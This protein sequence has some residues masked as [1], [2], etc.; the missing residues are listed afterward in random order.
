MGF[1]TKRSVLPPYRYIILDEAHHVEDVATEH[2]GVSLSKAG[3][4]RL[5]GRLQRIRRGKNSRASA[6][7]PGAVG[8]RPWHAGV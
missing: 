5:L 8:K 3:I 4:S 6:A 2:F 1:D 7:Y